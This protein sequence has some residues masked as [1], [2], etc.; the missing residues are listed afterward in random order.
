MKPLSKS[1]HYIKTHFQH[2]I[3]TPQVFTLEKQRRII[4]NNRLYV[5]HLPKLDFYF[6]LDIARQEKESAIATS[7]LFEIPY[8]F[9][10]NQYLSHLE[11]TSTVLEFQRSLHRCLINIDLF[12]ESSI[13]HNHVFLRRTS[14]YFY[15][16]IICFVNIIT[17]GPRCSWIQVY[18]NQE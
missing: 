1:Q 6:C 7:T 2:H 5:Y 11:R 17:Q 15:F 14:R 9:T 3:Q 10:E 13:Y 16:M 18:F 8:L 4:Q 12:T